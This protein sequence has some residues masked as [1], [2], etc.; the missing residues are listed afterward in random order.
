MVVTP[1]TS[2]SGRQA[3]WTSAHLGHTP[4]I[5]TRTVWIRPNR[6]LVVVKPAGKI[7]VEI[8]EIQ[9]EYAEK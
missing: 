9:E 8:S 6:T 1:M 7:S 5:R 4:V 3:L 2:I